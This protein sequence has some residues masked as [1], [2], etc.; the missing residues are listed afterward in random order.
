MKKHLFKAGIA[1]LLIS[2][3]AAVF[4]DD[5]ANT[6]PTVSS[7]GFYAGLETG[8]DSTSNKVWAAAGT[9]TNYDMV[10][11]LYGV[12]L[13]FQGPS[14]DGFNLSLEA[15][16]DGDKADTTQHVTPP[17][18]FYKKSEWG[19]S[20][21][22]GYAV[23]DNS[24]VYARLGYANAHIKFTGTNPSTAADSPD[25]TNNKSGVEMGLGYLL[26]LPHNLGVRAEYD[27][28][29]YGEIMYPT[30]DFSGTYASNEF[31]LGLEWMFAS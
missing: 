25:Y 31:R 27:Y 23:A 4:A 15:F 20:L 11:A 28:V 3:S 22:P 16:Y 29:Y 14:W 17:F 2:T 24:K 26:G 13:G 6:Y 10:G 21:L 30:A 1:G 5:A 9:Y 18:S 19:V 7:Q 12:F 8:V